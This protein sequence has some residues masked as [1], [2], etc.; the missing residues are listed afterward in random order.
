MYNLRK[1]QEVNT[2]QID[3]N[4]VKLKMMERGFSVKELAQKTDLAYAT[5]SR[6]LNSQKDFSYKTV[7]RISKALDC[8]PNDIIVQ[9]C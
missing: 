1:T 8:K 2:M 9:R 5:I 6:T 4:T 3:T 7:A